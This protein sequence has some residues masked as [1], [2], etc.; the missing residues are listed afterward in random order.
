VYDMVKAI[1]RSMS[2]DEVQLVSKSGGTRGDWRRA[3]S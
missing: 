2:I 3:E 1:D